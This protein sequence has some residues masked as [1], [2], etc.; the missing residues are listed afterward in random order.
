MNPNKKSR[1]LF[2]R[3]DCDSK[4]DMLD[5][6]FLFGS[7]KE[8]RVGRNQGKVMEE[9]LSTKT[10]PYKIP[11]IYALEQEERAVAIMRK[12]IE[13]INE[14]LIR[15][16]EESLALDWKKV[17][18]DLNAAFRRYKKSCTGTVE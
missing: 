17:G 7:R 3:E 2:K 1:R 14:D 16:E 8:T 10:L 11:D 4:K 5:Y 18:G 15:R 13:K 12:R 6:S 9:M